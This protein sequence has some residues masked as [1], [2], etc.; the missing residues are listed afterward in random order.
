MAQFSAPSEDAVTMRRLAHRADEDLADGSGID[1]TLLEQMEE[2]VAVFRRDATY[3]YVNPATERLFDKKRE[4]LIGRV[5]WEVFPG[6]QVGVFH[7]AFLR[8]AETG[9][10]EEFE[11][12]FEPWGRWFRNR[13]YR[14]GERIYVFSRDTTEERLRT[15]ALLLHAWIL[16]SMTEGV[17]L[18]D[19]GGRIVYT[20]PAVDRMFGYGRDELLGQPL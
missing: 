11:H 15:D 4:E 12:L 17:A 19:E 10:R 8:V 1:T 13:V 6:S 7:Q 9:Q 20:N 3:L 16:E 5:I 18:T 2:S 14:S